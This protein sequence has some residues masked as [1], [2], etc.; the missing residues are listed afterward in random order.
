MFLSNFLYYFV[1][2]VHLLYLVLE[3]RIDARSADTLDSYTNSVR[4]ENGKRV[5][6]REQE[7][8]YSDTV[9]DGHALV[10]PGVTCVGPIRTTPFGSGQSC[11]AQVVGLL[12]EDLVICC[13]I[14]YD[15]G[16]FRLH[17]AIL[18]LHY[19]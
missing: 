19:Q 17:N 7:E 4:G 14:V 6:L 5:G 18:T 1:S 15:A 11:V 8:E 12:S 2:F 3:S 13:V 10:P 9:V 16:I